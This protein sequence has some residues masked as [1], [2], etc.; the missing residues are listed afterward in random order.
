MTDCFD[1][2]R[3]GLVI[4]G[5]GY[6]HF[7]G[8]RALVGGSLDDDQ[9]RALIDPLSGRRILI[10][11]LA[12]DCATCGR[13]AF[14]RIDDLAQTNTCPHCHAASELGQAR[15]RQ[16][17]HEPTW[18][19]HLH[20]LARDL[21]NQH[22]E[23]PLLLADHLRR[24]SRRYADV[25][26]LELFSSASPIAECDLLASVDGRVVTAEAK[27]VTRFGRS[28]ADRNAA[29]KKRIR[30]ARVLRADEIVLATTESQ[31]NGDDV[32]AL[33]TAVRAARWSDGSPPAVRVVIGLGTT[34]IGEDLLPV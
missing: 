31:W 3:A 15:W 21:L 33:R 28:E 8:I 24:S 25:A 20:P 30:I 16:P 26:E 22:G 17:R 29:I 1:T 9:L 6:L 4:N 2:L 19:Y 18:Y 10:R 5:E 11:G 7:S 23:V 13:L 12:L 32:Q 34:S 27:S 14:L